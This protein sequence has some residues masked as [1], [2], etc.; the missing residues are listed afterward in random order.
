MPTMMKPGFT[1]IELLV[2]IVVISTLISLSIPALGKVRALARQHVC[3]T[4]IRSV[5]LLLGTYS[6]AYRD[7]LPFGPRER[8]RADWARPQQF[9]WGGSVGLRNG[10]WA[11]LFPEEWAGTSWNKAYECPSQ[12]EYV[13]SGG[14][15][16][17]DGWPTPAYCLTEAVWLDGVSMT[18]NGPVRWKLKP[19]A[20]AD[21]AYPSQKVYVTEWPG[22]C[23]TEPHSAADIEAG[24]TLSQRV[25][26]NFFDGSV[27]RNRVYDARPGAGG[28][29][30]VLWTA[31]GL[32]GL[33]YP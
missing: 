5:G 31:D 12:P 10:T 27:R 6:A 29:L 8:V 7:A 33:D 1:L 9:E 2:T 11:F 30:P 16:I 15:S 22:F 32:G 24:Q 14:A 26:M 3:D 17:W 18:A 23:L 21:V 4:R 20:H 19:N 13:P 25:A 28:S